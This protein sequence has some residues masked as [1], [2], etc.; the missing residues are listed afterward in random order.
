MISDSTGA[1]ET[2][3]YLGL[4]TVVIRRRA[5]TF[6]YFDLT[7]TGGGTGEAGDQYVG[8][9]RFGRVVD[10][11]WRTAFGAQLDHFQYAYDRDSNR[12]SR[13][14]LVTTGLDETYTY[15]GLNQL[16]SFQRG[17]HTQTWDVDALGNFDKVTTDGADQFRNHNK[18][19]IKG[20]RYIHA[21]AN[22]IVVPRKRARPPARPASKVYLSPTRTVHWGTMQ[23]MK[24][25][26]PSPQSPNEISEN[27][28]HWAHSAAAAG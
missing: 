10:Q 20:D 13:N 7:Y 27:N 8:L 3:V 9:D 14:N 12:T 22:A 21:A 26:P 6:L 28:L 1:L 19:P 15:D 5:D 24:R 11:Y 23:R 17:T 2:E 4:G 25:F 18:G 16:A